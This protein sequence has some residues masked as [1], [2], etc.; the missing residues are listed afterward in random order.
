MIEFRII[1]RIQTLKHDQRV[2]EAGILP[3]IR[4]KGEDGYEKICGD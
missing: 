2:K 3:S 1:F 4:S